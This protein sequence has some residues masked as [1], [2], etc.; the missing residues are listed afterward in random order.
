MRFGGDPILAM[1]SGGALD[2]AGLRPA[3]CPRRQET[4]P[5]TEPTAAQQIDARVAELGDWRSE[6]LARV[7]ALIHEGQVVDPEAF[8]TLMR[9]AAAANG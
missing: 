7:R 8:K 1:R 3:A 4:C 2:A 5:M 9:A 6:T